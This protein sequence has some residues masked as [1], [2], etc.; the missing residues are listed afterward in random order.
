MF[1]IAWVDASIDGLVDLSMLSPHLI[2]NGVG[3]LA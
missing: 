2:L 1:Q 3:H